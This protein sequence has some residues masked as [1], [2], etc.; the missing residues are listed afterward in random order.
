M[1]IVI[2]G[3]VGV[4]KTT[5]VEMIKEEAEKEQNH[6]IKIF[7]ESVGIDNPFLELYYQ[8]KPEW[9][10]LTQINFLIDRFKNAFQEEKEEEL[11]IFDRHFLDDY[12]WM[13]LN[14]VRDNMFNLQVNLY[15][16]VNRVFVEKLKE[17][18]HVEYFFLLKASFENV[19]KRI[20]KRNRLEEK[21]IDE[22]YWKQLYHVYYNDKKVQEYLVAH[23]ENLIIIETDNKSPEEVKNEIM[24]IINKKTR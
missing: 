14:P 9:S 23:T 7:Y 4:G 10:F 8:D 2:S 6:K 19:I 3:T 1:N 12:I 24:S 15:N 13:Q 5:V 18:N 22:T 17:R 16:Q 21:I 20:K 11:K